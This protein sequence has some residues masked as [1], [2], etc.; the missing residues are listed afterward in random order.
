MVGLGRHVVLLF[1]G[2][3]NSLNSSA[4]FKAAIIS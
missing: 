2:Q 4:R 1:W 3:G